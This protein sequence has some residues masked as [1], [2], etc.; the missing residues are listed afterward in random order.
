MGDDGLHHASGEQGAQVRAAWLFLCRL[1]VWLYFRLHLY[2]A[3]SNLYRLIWEQEFKGKPLHSF[4][5]L[6]EVGEY[7]RLKAGDWRA[8]SWKQLGDA[9]SYPQKAQAVFDR[10]VPVPEAGLDCDEF[11][12]FLT[13]VLQ[14]SVSDGTFTGPEAP[15]PRFFTVMWLEGW[16]PAGH[17]VCLVRH[18]GHYAYMDYGQPVG[19]EDTIQSLA[20]SISVRYGAPDAVLISHVVQDAALKPLEVNWG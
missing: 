7:M 14:Q 20:E 13:A 19:H 2:R 18:K 17:N 6:E 4:K 8:D 11:A 5:S 1:G 16:K 10:A 3:W 9:V 15:V 12:I